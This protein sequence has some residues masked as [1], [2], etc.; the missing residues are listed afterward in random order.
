MAKDQV[1]AILDLSKVTQV[2]ED[3][4]QKKFNCDFLSK[5]SGG[6]LILGN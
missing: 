6:P 3:W 1:C 4:K 5:G 2:Y